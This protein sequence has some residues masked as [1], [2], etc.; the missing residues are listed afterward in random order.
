MK[1]EV[2]AELADLVCA[3]QTGAAAVFV[4]EEGLFGKDTG[5][6]TEWVQ[7]QPA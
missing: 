6:L 5:P 1:V 7:R 4:A 2:C 3:L